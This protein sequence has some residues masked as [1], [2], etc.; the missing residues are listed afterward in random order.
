MLLDIF[1]HGYYFF[2][3]EY[4]SQDKYAVNW[5]VFYISGEYN[6]STQLKRN[7]S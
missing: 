1:W 4:F 6:K 3:F 2:P 7:K 5:K